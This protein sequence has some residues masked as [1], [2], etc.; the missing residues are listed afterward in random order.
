M[1]NN[2]ANVATVQAIY[3]AFGRGDLPTILSKLS[4]D[5]TWEYGFAPNEVPWLQHGRGHQGVI[6]FFEALAG[7]LQLTHFAPK[8]LLVGQDKV[9]ALID[10]RGK[11]LKTGVEVAE[12]DEVHIWH[13]GEGGKINR[14]RHVVDSLQHHRAYIGG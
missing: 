3:E 13:F 6:A 8:E 1:H 12:T 10:I 7:G 9:V 4:P 11:V 5:I 2:E 14:F